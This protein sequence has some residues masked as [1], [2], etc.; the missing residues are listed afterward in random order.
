MCNSLIL[1]ACMSGPS[2]H[3]LYMCARVEELLHKRS[4]PSFRGIC[5]PVAVRRMMRGSRQ[6]TFRMRKMGAEA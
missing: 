3:V 5:I 2:Q 4:V 1:K 6:G